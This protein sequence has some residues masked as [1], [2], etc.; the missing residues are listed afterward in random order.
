MALACGEHFSAVVTNSGHIFAWGKGDYAQLGLSTYEHKCFPSSINIPARLHSVAAGRL[1]A[2]AVAKDGALWVWGSN[3]YCQLGQ[4]DKQS[5]LKPTP[6]DKVVFGGA[7]VAMA[8]CGER[9]TV[10]ITADGGVWTFGQNN[11]GQLGHGDTSHRNQPFRVT[12]QSFQDS[13][14]VKVAAGAF[15]NVAMCIQVSFNI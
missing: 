5:S 12:A 1:H 7:T 2:I 3:N 15:H 14:I 11:V 4:A 6:L 9:H 10:A 8:D 13:K